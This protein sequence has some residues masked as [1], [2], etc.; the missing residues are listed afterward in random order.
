MVFNH[1][2]VQGQKDDATKKQ[3]REVRV[4]FSCRESIIA[5]IIIF[6]DEGFVLDVQNV[7][8]LHWKMG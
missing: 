8:R 3:E 2:I 7:Q 5:A 4:A 6:L 1:E